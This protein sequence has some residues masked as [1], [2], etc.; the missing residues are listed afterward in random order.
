[1]GDNVTVLYSVPGLP[2]GVTPDPGSIKVSMDG[3]TV[4]AT[5]KPVADAGESPRRTSVLAIDVSQSM[6]GAKFKAAKAAAQAYVDAAPKD[7]YVGLVTFAS[8][9]KTVQS[10]TQDHAALTKAIGSLELSPATH[11]Y[12][13]VLK[14]L[15]ETGD[16]GQRSI[17]LLSDG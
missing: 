13:G 3:K 12:D 10:P 8:D 1:K 4:K 7:V 5:A 14:A 15:D 6:A 16:E 2:N 9:V 17:L 11:L